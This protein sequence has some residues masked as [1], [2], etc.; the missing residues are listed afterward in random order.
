M[1]KFAPHI[2][3]HV[4]LHVVLPVAL[5]A[6]S[7]AA[8]AELKKVFENIRGTVVYVDTA[9]VTPSGDKRRVTE[10][11]TYRTAGPRGMMSM[12]LLK[13]YDCKNETAQIISYVMY[14]EPMARG[15]VIGT[16]NT[17]GDVQKLTQNPG[18]TG[19]WRFACGL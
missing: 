12:K 4:A 11:Q 1:K 9:S 7:A 6:A 8:H 16:V 5:L 3:L 13:E 14:K 10:V 17:R 2:S 19:G 15:E 18:G